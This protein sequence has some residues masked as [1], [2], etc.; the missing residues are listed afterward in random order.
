[1]IRVANGDTTWTAG[2]PIAVSLTDDELATKCGG[3]PPSGFINRIGISAKWSEASLIQVNMAE[4]TVVAQTGASL[5]PDLE[6]MP[7]RHSA[8]DPPLEILA[9]EADAELLGE[10]AASIV[11]F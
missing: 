8:S 1:M 10:S 7:S 9:G 2:K 5:H 4:T 6:K 3:K 11:L